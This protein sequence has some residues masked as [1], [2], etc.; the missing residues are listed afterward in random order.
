MQPIPLAVVANTIKSNK[1]KLQQAIYAG[2]TRRIVDGKRTIVYL[3][4]TGGT[5]REARNNF[6]KSE[7]FGENIWRLSS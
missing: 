2:W 1:D 6:K 3:L 5:T 7:A 4:A